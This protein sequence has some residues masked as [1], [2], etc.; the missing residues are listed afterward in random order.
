MQATT[1]L[2]QN[3]PGGG[4]SRPRDELPASEWFICYP[5]TI[6]HSLEWRLWLSRTLRQQCWQWQREAVGRR[7]R[8]WTGWGRQPGTQPDRRSESQCTRCL[9]ECRV[10][11][12]NLG[13]P[14]RW[15]TWRRQAQR[16]IQEPQREMQKKIKVGNFFRSCFV[17]K[18]TNNPSWWLTGVRSQSINKCERLKVS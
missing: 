16:N 10:S 2:N 17:N 5:P 11:W 18:I 12:L 1:V 4:T 6:T 8:W 15:W 13:R 3:M 14:Q 7:A 9:P